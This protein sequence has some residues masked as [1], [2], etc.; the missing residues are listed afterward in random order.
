LQILGGEID[1]DTGDLL[2]VPDFVLALF[3]ARRP[4]HVSDVDSNAGGVPRPR[5][6]LARVA[7]A[8]P[9]SVSIKLFV[10]ADE[11]SSGSVLLKF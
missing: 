3:P 4:A 2:Q 10:D 6:Y 8:A 11:S 5:Q 1:I 7:R 9:C